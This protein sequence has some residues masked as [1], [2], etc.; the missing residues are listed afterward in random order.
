MTVVADSVCVTDENRRQNT[1]RLPQNLTLGTQMPKFEAKTAPLPRKG[2][3][4]VRVSSRLDSPMGFERPKL[5]QKDGVTTVPKALT[6][7]TA[8]LRTYF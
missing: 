2:S 1:P 7:G 5:G 4:S 8:A 3:P 6:S